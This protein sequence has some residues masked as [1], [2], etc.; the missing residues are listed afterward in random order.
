MIPTILVLNKIDRTDLP[1]E[2]LRDSEGSIVA[3]RISALKG[4]GLD[5]L[6]EAIR[7]KAREMKEI[8]K[9]VPREPE[10]WEYFVQE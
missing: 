4:T 7:E 6:R 5:L 9:S 3:V 1:A 2:I 8:N 10:E